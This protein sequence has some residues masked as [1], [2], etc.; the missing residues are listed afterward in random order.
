MPKIVKSSSHT[1]KFANI[2]KQDKLCEFLAEYNRVKYE[3]EL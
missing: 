3:D 1:A 2:G